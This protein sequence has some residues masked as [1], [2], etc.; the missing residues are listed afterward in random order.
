MHTPRK[1]T[2]RFGACSEYFSGA[3]KA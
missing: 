1:V 3:P 2:Q